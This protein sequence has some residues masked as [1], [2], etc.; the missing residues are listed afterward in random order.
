MELNFIVDSRE[1]KLIDLL[2]GK[3]EKFTINQM[4]VGDFLYK[5]KNDE[6]IL[7]IERKSY[8]D[9]SSSIQS[10]RYNEQKM[11]LES[12]SCKWKAYLIEGPY[13]KK[14]Y[15]RITIGALD[16]AIMGLS[17]RDGFSVIYSQDIN[18][19]ME[20]LVKLKKKII[21]WHKTLNSNKV[22]QNSVYIS[23][24]KTKKMEN[25]NPKNCYI[26]QLCQ[27]PGVSTKVAEAIYL[28]YPTMIKFVNMLQSNIN[29]IDKI[30]NIKMTKRKIG[31]VLAEKIVLFCNPSANNSIKKKLTIIRKK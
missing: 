19:S 1:L 7:V 24:I 11:R 23:N 25:I 15:G 2:K 9:L 5:N 10:G 31:K 28:E 29:S 12:F 17:I 27:I 4:D 30:S 21:D 14:T 18:H 8:G 22:N 26:L 13:P 3:N 20:L 6:N 16:S